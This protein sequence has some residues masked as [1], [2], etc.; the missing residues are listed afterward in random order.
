MSQLVHD[1]IRSL[2][3][4]E[5]AWFKRYSGLSGGGDAKNYLR[6][7]EALVLQRVYDPEALQARFA[8]ESLG[9]HLHSELNYLMEQVLK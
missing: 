3:A 9:R 4:R 8:G 2:S 1:L 7:Y 6:L 5:K